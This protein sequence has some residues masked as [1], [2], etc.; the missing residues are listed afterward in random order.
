MSDALFQNISSTREEQKFK[1]NNSHCATCDTRLSPG[2]IF[3]LVC[4]PP[5]SPS[6]APEEVGI[7]FRQAMLRIAIIIAL[8]VAIALGKLE[9]SFDG[10]SLDEKNKQETLAGSDQLK[11]KDFQTFHTIAVSSANIRSNPSIKAKIILTA[12]KGVNLE[13]IVRDKNWSKVRVLKK[14]GWISNKLFKSE[15]IAQ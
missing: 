4:D 6:M 8:F 12:A 1:K 3:C 2:A 5:L 15:I 14:T 7:S 9:T 10:P 11:D 13:V